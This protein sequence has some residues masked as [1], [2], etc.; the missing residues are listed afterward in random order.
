MNTRITDKLDVVA[1]DGSDYPDL[2]T[3]SKTTVKAHFLQQAID[4]VEA[5]GWDTVDVCAVENDTSDKPLLVV[6]PPDESVLAGE[7]AAILVA[8]YDASDRTL[9]GDNE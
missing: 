8:P 9:G 4:V 7:Q 1:L 3:A 5:L 6:Q 2:E